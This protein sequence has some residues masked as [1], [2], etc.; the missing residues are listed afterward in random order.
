M[1]LLL[2]QIPSHV[3]NAERTCAYLREDDS[4]VAK[5]ERFEKMYE[6]YLQDAVERED[7]AA[8][9]RGVGDTLMDMV[10]E[11]GSMRLMLLNQ[12]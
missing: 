10:E 9:E 8:G 1:A 2:G 7:G 3:A 5:Y 4:Y 12:V 11:K 6:R